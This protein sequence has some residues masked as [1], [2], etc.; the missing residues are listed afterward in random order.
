M[1]PFI[2]SFVCLVL[3]LYPYLYKLYVRLNGTLVY[4]TVVSFDEQREW[5]PRG[6]YH[7][8]F[9]AVLSYQID[10]M[11]YKTRKAIQ[12]PRQASVGENV[13]IYCL[14]SN[15]EKIT[16]KGHN[17]RGKAYHLLFVVMGAGLLFAGIVGIAI[18]AMFT[19]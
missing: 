13:E 4:A 12:I 17:I 7:H 15:P 11:E 10:G 19:Y 9:F 2:V 8:S 14:K 16:P 1:W 3:G 6:G 5:I 18:S